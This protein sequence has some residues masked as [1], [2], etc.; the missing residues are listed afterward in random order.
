MH[1]DA[2]L[3]NSVS[4]A[5]TQASATACG[6]RLCLSHHFRRTHRL[7]LSGR[8]LPARLLHGGPHSFPPAL[9]ETPTQNGD[10]FGL[11]IDIELF[12]RIKNIGKRML[13]AH[14]NLLCA[15]STTSALRAEDR[16]AQGKKAYPASPTVRGVIRDAVVCR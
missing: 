5:R 15:Q 11:G 4:H 6:S 7:A 1:Q 3:A 12:G 13:L 9:G 16:Q 8:K 14:R 2:P 10:Q